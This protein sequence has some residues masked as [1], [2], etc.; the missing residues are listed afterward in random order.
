MEEK[1]LEEANGEA[2]AVL[3]DKITP[4]PHELLACL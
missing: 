3:G 1:E 4:L 2:H